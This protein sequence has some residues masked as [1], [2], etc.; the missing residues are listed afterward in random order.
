MENERFIERITMVIN[1]LNAA[2]LRAD[3]IDAV[4]RIDACTRELKGIIAE[5]NTA[6]KQKKK[7][8]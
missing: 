5:L 2:T 4:Q 1:T 6:D 3:Q 8:E 7:E